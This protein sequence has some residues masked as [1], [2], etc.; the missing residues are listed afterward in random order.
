ME[1]L[2]EL[3]KRRSQQS[4]EPLMELESAV[5]ECATVH[6]TCTCIRESLVDMHMPTCTCTC[7]NNCA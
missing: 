3:S 5:D 2:Q 7:V 4:D 6:Y 1:E